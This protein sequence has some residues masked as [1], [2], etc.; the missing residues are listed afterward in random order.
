MKKCDQRQ[1]IR[2]ARLRRKR[3]LAHEREKQRRLHKHGAIV[4]KNAINRKRQRNQFVLMTV[5]SCFDFISNAENLLVFFNDL[6][7][8]LEKNPVRLDMSKVTEINSSALLYLISLVQ[9]MKMKKKTFVI[10]GNLP[11]DKKCCEVMEQSGF[12]KYAK[13]TDHARMEDK[14]NTL[15]ISSSGKMDPHK[16]SQ[17]CEF[18]RNKLEVD[19][20]GTKWLYSVI[21][22]IILN[23]THHALS[24]W[25]EEFDSWYMFAKY[26]DNYVELVILDT[27]LGIPNTVKKNFLEKIRLWPDSDDASLIQSALNGDFRTQTKQGY[28]GKGLPE[29]FNYYANG[30]IKNIVIISKH[31]Y[32]NGREKKN[33]TGKFN[34]TL[35][36]L[37]IEKHE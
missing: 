2:N 14:G 22:E 8:N 7:K 36:A 23:A 37:R 31:G 9:D 12:F 26:Q 15:Q 35:F 27:G 4:D 1:R 24:H 13:R 34:G 17:C 29:I 10:H 25:K 30:V 33:L 5:P 11:N 6:R 3:T 19:R 16:V 18:V 32:I 20:L 28:R 21:C